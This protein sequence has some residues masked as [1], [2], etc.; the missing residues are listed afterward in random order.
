MRTSAIILLLLLAACVSKA[1]KPSHQPRSPSS[2]EPAFSKTLQPIIEKWKKEDPEKLETA[3]KD[4]PEEHRKNFTLAYNSG[5]LQKGSYL[6]PR[7]I[8]FGHSG[9]TVFTFNGDPKLG[10]YSSLEI[11]DFDEGKNLLNFYEVRFKKEPEVGS[12]EDYIVLT[13]DE[14]LMETDNLQ[15]SRANP[16]KC[17]NCHAAQFTSKDQSIRFARYIWSSYSKWP[18]VYGSNDDA[19]GSSIM[20]WNTKDKRREIDYF[21]EFRKSVDA[22]K[23]EHSRYRTLTFGSLDADPYY[24]EYTR[25]DKITSAYRKIA[26]MPNSRLTML[27]AANY[28]RMVAKF[29]MSEPELKKD[30]SMYLKEWICN[31]KDLIFYPKSL[32]D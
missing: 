6:F 13:A 12:S 9:E 7:A 25:S 15:I 14:I 4:L 20:D 19:L 3:L 27:L 11:A 32:R 29:V 16:T 2:V 1:P 30:N 22:N 21:R 23:D 5:S 8:L 31:E 24:Y 17:M 18:G 10:G 28:S 26:N